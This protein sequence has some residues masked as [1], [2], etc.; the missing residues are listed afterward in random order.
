MYA[1]DHS[2]IDQGTL[3]EYDLFQPIYA[4]SAAIVLTPRCDIAQDKAEFLTLAAVVPSLVLLDQWETLPERRNQLSG[5]MDDRPARWH[6]LAP[7]TAFPYGAVIDFQLVASSASDDLIGATILCALAGPWREHM[8]S[9]YAAYASRVG[10]P[11]VPR[12]EIRL[13]RDEILKAY[14]SRGNAPPDPQ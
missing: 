10:I 13:V 3:V 12:A 9:R 11:D 2:S 7:D 14:E 1:Y 5:I 8:A 4:G 6:W